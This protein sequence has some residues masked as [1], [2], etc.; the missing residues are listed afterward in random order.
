MISGVPALARGRRT[1]QRLR[2]DAQAMTEG[3]MTLVDV[4]VFLW[5]LFIID[6]FW[7]R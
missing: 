4:V 3:A 6:A 5:A 2:I 1:T 7:G